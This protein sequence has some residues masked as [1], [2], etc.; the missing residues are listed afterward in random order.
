MTSWRTG[1]HVLWE[2]ARLSTC[3]VGGKLWTKQDLI[4]VSLHMVGDDR[5]RWRRAPPQP[6]LYTGMARRDRPEREGRWRS[7]MAFVRCAV[8]WLCKTRTSPCIVPFCR[9]TPRLDRDPIHIQWCSAILN[10]WMLDSY[11]I[12]ETRCWRILKQ[13]SC[14][15]KH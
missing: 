6:L 7:A 2:E 15:V 14:A 4:C 9:M 11:P 13:K 8:S 5:R 10:P 12:S 1:K 3:Q